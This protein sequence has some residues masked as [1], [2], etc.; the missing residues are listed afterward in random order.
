MILANMVLSKK[1]FCQYIQSES[2][3]GYQEIICQ[4]TTYVSCFRLSQHS[5]NIDRT[6]EWNTKKYWFQ[7]ESGMIDL[8]RMATDSLKRAAIQLTSSYSSE[9]AGT[10]ESFVER[11]LT[12][13]PGATNG[14]RRSMETLPRVKSASPLDDTSPSVWH[15]CSIAWRKSRVEPNNSTR[16]Y[17]P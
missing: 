3:A 15:G 5:R 6:Y 12:L 17:V 11:V 4:R 8:R 14:C 10:R 2:D 13:H 1:I 16:D 9:T 7:Y